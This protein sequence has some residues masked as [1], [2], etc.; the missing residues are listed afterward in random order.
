VKQGKQ[1]AICELNLAGLED[2]ISVLSGTT[3]TVELLNQIRAELGAD[4]KP[5]DWLPVF[6]D[7]RKQQ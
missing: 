1:S 6:H 7:R 5:A 2:V 4:T 3:A